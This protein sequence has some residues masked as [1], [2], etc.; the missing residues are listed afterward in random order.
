MSVDSSVIFHSDVVAVSS[1][2]LSALWT[3]RYIINDA[4]DKATRSRQGFAALPDRRKLP[5][6]RPFDSEKGS[7]S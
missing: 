2:G 1:L 5:P 7:D 6:D 3:N 4:I